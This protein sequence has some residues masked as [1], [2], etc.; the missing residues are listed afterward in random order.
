MG[1]ESRSDPKVENRGG[2]VAKK[3]RPE[4][5]SH[6]QSP[7]S[8]EV[9]RRWH[10]VMPHFGPVASES[11]GCTTVDPTPSSGRA[12]PGKIRVTLPPDFAPPPP[13]SARDT[14]E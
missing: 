14:R 1:S 13:R 9:L 6:K 11:A 10:H 8:D 4:P 3:I 2:G 12:T 7:D 5:V